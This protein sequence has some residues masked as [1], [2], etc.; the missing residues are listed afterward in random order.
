MRLR[1]QVIGALNLF[2]SE[3]GSLDS[4]DVVVA[5]A[6]AD[7]A[8]IAILQHRTALEASVLNDQLNQALTSR[9][10][11]EQAKGMVAERER[12]DMA[13]GLRR[14]ARV[15]PQPQ[16]SSGRCRCRRRRRDARPHDAQAADVVTDDTGCR[17]NRGPLV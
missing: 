13:R 11:L 6:L 15:R 14:A 8:T 12:V 10:V 5:Q 7:I 16:R 2:R 4:E 9:I 17:W 1:R 3:T